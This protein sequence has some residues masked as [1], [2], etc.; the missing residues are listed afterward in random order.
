MPLSAGVSSQTTYQY[1]LVGR[2]LTMTDG[3]GHTTSFGYDVL[4]RQT[5]KT[6]PDLSFEQYSYDNVGNVNEI[7]DVQTGA[8]QDFSYDHLDRLTF[9]NQM[10]TSG[11]Y[12]TTF[13][14][15]R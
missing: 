4:G 3:N 15:H 11:G 13:P 12:N 14:S 2:L 7:D 8:L 10:G 1:D 9:A 5:T 6:L